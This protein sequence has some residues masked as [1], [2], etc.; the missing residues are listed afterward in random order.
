MKRLEWLLFK[1]RITNN[2]TYERY[3]DGT[4]KATIHRTDNISSNVRPD[5]SRIK[6]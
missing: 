3:P 1:L 5:T 2:L 6:P 4:A